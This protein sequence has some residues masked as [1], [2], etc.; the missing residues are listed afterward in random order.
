MITRIKYKSSHEIIDEIEQKGIDINI[1]DEFG[2]SLVML[3]LLDK[4]VELVYYLLERN[5]DLSTIVD[6]SNI[7][8][9]H[10]K[11]NWDESWDAELMS[12]LMEKGVDIHL[13]DKNGNQPL[14]YAAFNNKGFGRTLDL[15][16]V[17][18]KAGANMHHQNIA[19]RAPKMIAELTND[20][21][22]LKLFNK[23]DKM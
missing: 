7:A 3:A 17:L 2:Y 4:K 9:Y 12:K 15:V 5:V 23:Y 8:H 16:E 11:W 10:C 18:L 20:P 14:W 21:E 1:K 13:N 22:L 6:S 19:G